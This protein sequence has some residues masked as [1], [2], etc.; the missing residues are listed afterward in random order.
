MNRDEFAA[1][2]TE[3]AEQAYRQVATAPQESEERAVWSRVFMALNQAEREL[4]E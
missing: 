2:I 3:L 4:S 1:K